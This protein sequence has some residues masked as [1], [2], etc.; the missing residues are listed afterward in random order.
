MSTSWNGCVL[1][2][3]NSRSRSESAEWRDPNSITSPPPLVTSAI[4]RRMKARIISSLSS[5]SVCTISRI[6]SA[7]IAIASPACHRDPIAPLP[8]SQRSLSRAAAQRAHLAAEAT[9]REHVQKLLAA[10][11]VL[12]DLYASREHDEHVHMTTAGL[13]QNLSALGLDA[14]PVALEARQLR[15]A[16]LGKHLLAT[17]L[18]E[19]V[20]H[21]S[22]PRLPLMSCPNSD[23]RSVCS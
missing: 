22:S 7:S 12:Q 13:R 11:I 5:A 17:L 10:M 16:E 18:Q 23:G 3:R 14:P 9:R 15:R 1:R 4:R 19:L 21:G 2:V 6:C 20:H 8:R